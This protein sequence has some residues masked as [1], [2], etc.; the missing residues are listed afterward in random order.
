MSGK[1]EIHI[2]LHHKVFIIDDETVVLG[3]YNFSANADESN[4]ENLLVI[5]SAD[6]AKDFVSEF[7]RVYN[8]A[9]SQKE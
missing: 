2:P 5:H 8:Q 4:D 9:Q 1:M 3:S 6:I 7:N